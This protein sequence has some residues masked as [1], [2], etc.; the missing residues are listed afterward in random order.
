MEAE[1]VRACHLAMREEKQ[2]IASQ[3][4]P[5]Q[6]RRYY[7]ELCSPSALSS[8]SVSDAVRERCRGYA[9]DLTGCMHSYFRQV[10]A[11]DL[12]SSFRSEEEEQA[13]MPY[14]YSEAD[15]RILQAPE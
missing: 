3:L 4:C 14:E 6:A 7:S 5:A 15:E 2:C 11:R 10:A 8:T 1:E 12:T 9:Y 13:V